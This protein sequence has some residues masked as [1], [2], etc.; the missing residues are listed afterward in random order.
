M[1]ASHDMRGRSFDELVTTEC[2]LGL[3]S[4]MLR[5]SLVALEHGTTA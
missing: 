2:N 5:S 3:V 4:K 1:L